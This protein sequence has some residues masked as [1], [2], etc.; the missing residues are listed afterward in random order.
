MD[1]P[2]VPMWMLG[3]TAVPRPDISIRIAGHAPCRSHATGVHPREPAVEHVRHCLAVRR[4]PARLEL[5]AQ[6]RVLVHAC[7]VS[8]SGC[9]QRL[10]RSARRMPPLPARSPTRRAAHHMHKE[11]RHRKRRLLGVPTRAMPCLLDTARGSAVLQAAAVGPCG[12]ERRA[13]A[14]QAP[15]HDEAPDMV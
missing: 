4:R 13:G 9:L 3:T 10:L 6:V 14:H 15:L 1:E 5:L 8:R 11:H 2:R 12:C 7:I